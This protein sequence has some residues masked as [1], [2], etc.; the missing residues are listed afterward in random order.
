MAGF[1][2]WEDVLLDEDMVST[3]IGLESTNTIDDLMNIGDPDSVTLGLAVDRRGNLA[4]RFEEMTDLPQVQSSVYEP[5]VIR[6]SLKA[7]G[8]TASRIPQAAVPQS[9]ASS[10][11]APLPASYAPS[12][13]AID[14]SLLEVSDLGSVFDPPS[15]EGRGK[16][17][18]GSQPAVQHSAM[19]ASF[20]E[21]AK[22]FAAQQRHERAL[23]PAPVP[24]APQPQVAAPSNPAPTGGSMQKMRRHF[25]ATALLDAQKKLSGLLQ[26]GEI[27]LQVLLGRAAQLASSSIPGVRLVALAELGDEGLEPRHQIGA[28]DS[29]RQVITEPKRMDFAPSLLV[30][31]V[32]SLELDELE[33]PTPILSLMLIRLAPSPEN[34]ERLRGTLS[35][36]GQVSALQGANFLK[37]LVNLLESPLS[38]M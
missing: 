20:I 16:R 38:L 18:E 26:L 33:L 34:P 7:Q 22:E 3:L 36:N 30:T 12:N 8:Q 10:P 9:V 37:A 6:P 1:E 28:H 14:L 17:E 11:Q 25:D 13:D 2:E 19:P 24:A 31:D 21:A 29:L 32:S 35:L 23:T 27:P 15:E 5:P 4:R